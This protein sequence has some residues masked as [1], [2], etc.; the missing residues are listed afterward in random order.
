LL[1]AQAN[2]ALLCQ[3]LRG[4]VDHCLEHFAPVPEL[5]KLLDHLRKEISLVARKLDRLG[6][7]QKEGIN[8]SHLTYPGISLPFDP[9]DIL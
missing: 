7:P 6:A 9:L 2:K 5:L 3:V 4:F 1:V 8:N